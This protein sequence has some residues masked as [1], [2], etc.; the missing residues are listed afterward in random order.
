MTYSEMRSTTSGAISMRS[1]TAVAPRTRD[2]LGCLGQRL[3]RHFDR[4]AA[5]VVFDAGFDRLGFRQFL[6]HRHRLPAQFVVAAVLRQRREDMGA[7]I[8]LVVLERHRRAEQRNEVLAHVKRLVFLA[9]ED[10]DRALGRRFFLLGIQRFSEA[11]ENRPRNIRG[12]RVD[13][14][15]CIGPV[16]GRCLL[17]LGRRRSWLLPRASH[18]AR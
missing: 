14:G 2:R 4:T 16:F 7:E 11:R 18:H 13:R 10:R 1:S 5:T 8:R 12:P 6:R 15:G 3:D 17:A 9:D